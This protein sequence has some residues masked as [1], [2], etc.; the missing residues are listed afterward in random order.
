[1]LGLHLA[2]QRADGLFLLELCFGALIGDS[3]RE[4]VQQ[5]VVLFFRKV[6]LARE[7][8]PAMRV[9]M[10]KTGVRAFMINLPGRVSVSFRAGA[11]RVEA[12]Q[13]GAS[14]EPATRGVQCH[15]S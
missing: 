12:R 10:A 3:I 15:G 5:L 4:D 2:E 9:V 7:I 1:L 13:S 6:L 11:A 14:P 8:L